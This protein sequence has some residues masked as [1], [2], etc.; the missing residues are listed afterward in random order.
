M[1][2]VALVAAAVAVALLSAT[3]GSAIVFR[4]TLTAGSHRPAV[5]TRWPYTVKVVDARQR[6]LR[7]RV[8]AQVVDPLGGVHP[9]EFYANT[10]LVKDIPFRGVFRD[11]V[12][13][14]P[15]SRGFQLTFRI[16][17]KVGTARRTL[18]YRVTPQ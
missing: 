2:R 10:K 15:E 1:K 16:I 14:P 9:T 11:A 6:L 4:A 7:A 8:T 12:K 13:W 18:S 17:V 3:A 5:N